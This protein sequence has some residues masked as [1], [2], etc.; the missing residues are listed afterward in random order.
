VLCS[1]LLPYYGRRLSC[2][3]VIAQENELKLVK[4]YGPLLDVLPELKR[5]LRFSEQSFVIAS[6]Q[7]GNSPEDWSSVE[8]RILSLLMYHALNTSYSIRFLTT[9]G[10]PIEAFGLLRIRFEQLIVSSFLIHS[11]PEEGFTAFNSD[12]GRTDYRYSNAIQNID[13][14]LYATIESIFSEK[15]EEAK[16]D[17][18]FNELIN[19]PDFDFENDKLKKSWCSHNKF[20][21][22]ELRDK[23]S[24]KNDLISS[25]RFTHLY[26]SIYKSASLFVHSEPAILTKNFLSSH[27]GI[28]FPNNFMVIT[29]LINLAQLDLIQTYEVLKHIKPEASEKHKEMYMQFLK[30]VLIDY[31]VVV[32]K[33]KNAP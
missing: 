28:P 26:L 6:E 19:D 14:N 11:S 16:I 5:Y 24:D 31:D 8:A 30:N 33:I 13:P 10:Q 20:K 22:C 15:I 12:I 9:H 1:K 27:N 7:G 32:E 4:K 21:M 23:Q 2:H 25:V 3:A 17:A 18:H 29:N